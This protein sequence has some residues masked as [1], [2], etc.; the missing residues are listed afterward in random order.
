MRISGEKRPFEMT[1]P[2]LRS[3]LIEKVMRENRAYVGTPPYGFIR[4][5]QGKRYPEP[6]N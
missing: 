4:Q 1:F 5:V 2:E 6:L 3:H